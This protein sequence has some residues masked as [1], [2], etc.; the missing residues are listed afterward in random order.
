MIARAHNPAGSGLTILQQPDYPQ[1]KG[2][3]ECLP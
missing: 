2:P 3:D 1:L